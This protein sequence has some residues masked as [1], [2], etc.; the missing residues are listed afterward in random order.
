MSKGF[1]RKR[2]DV[3]EKLEGE[4]VLKAQ[5]AKLQSGEIEDWSIPSKVIPK[6][7]KPKPQLAPLPKYVRE[8]APLS[9]EQILTIRRV[10]EDEGL[11]LNHAAKATG[12]TYNT[13]GRRMAAHGIT[14]RP[15][16]YC[17]NDALSKTLG[18]DRRRA[19]EQA[20]LA[21]KTAKPDQEDE[22]V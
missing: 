4:D 7:P 8:P 15:T 9:E 18:A 22:E 12:L 3:F 6:P 19:M 13:L 2:M 21:A 11:T 20:K 14:I 16:L 10:L 17:S 5:W 1:R